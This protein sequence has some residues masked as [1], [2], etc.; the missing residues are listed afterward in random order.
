M[1][2]EKKMAEGEERL[3]MMEIA[4]RILTE[5]KTQVSGSVA[6]A[7][8]RFLLSEFQRATLQGHNV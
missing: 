1:G 2:E 5:H 8:Q 3:H 6:R 4:L 7:A